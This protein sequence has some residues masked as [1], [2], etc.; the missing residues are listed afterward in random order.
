VNRCSRQA[1][2]TPARTTLAACS[3]TSPSTRGCHVTYFSKRAPGSCALISSMF[4]A[5][6]VQLPS[7]FQ[8]VQKSV[9]KV[10]NRH[11][12]LIVVRTI[13]ARSS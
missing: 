3:W 4:P 10:I 5:A 12:S 1:G 9:D 8:A 11:H 7:T 6:H 2:S 13:T